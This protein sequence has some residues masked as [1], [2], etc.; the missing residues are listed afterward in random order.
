MIVGTK[1]RTE[2]I[3]PQ[4]PAG[5]GTTNSVPD[6]RNSS[7]DT[8][9]VPIRRL[10]LTAVTPPGPPRFGIDAIVPTIEEVCDYLFHVHDALI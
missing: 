5:K 8:E 6:S 1:I 3:S 9:P 4:I 2:P 7:A 10:R